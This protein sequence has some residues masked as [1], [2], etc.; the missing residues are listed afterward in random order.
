MD[1][2]ATVHEGEA[3]RPDSAALFEVRVRCEGQLE[4][5]SMRYHPRLF[6]CSLALASR[7]AEGRCDA[8]EPAERVRALFAAA[9]ESV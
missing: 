2:S 6:M 5:A 9:L 1:G 4:V 3:P 8:A 7:G